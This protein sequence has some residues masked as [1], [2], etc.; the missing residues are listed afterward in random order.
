M[1]EALKSRVIQVKNVVRYRSR[2]W[3]F[4]WVVRLVDRFASIHEIDGHRVYWRGIPTNPVVVDLGGNIGRF[5]N[6]ISKQLTCRVIYVEADPELCRRV[7]FAETAKVEIRNL[8]IGDK[9]EL[10]RLFRSRNSEAT[11]AN[12]VIADKGG[13]VDAFDVQGSTFNFFLERENVSYVDILKIDIEGS[14]IALL[15]S[16]SSETIKRIGQISVEFH[17]FVD[18]SYRPA[19]AR[20]LALLRRNGF[21]DIVYSL[22][23]YSKVLLLNKFRLKLSVSDRV[24]IWLIRNVLARICEFRTTRRFSKRL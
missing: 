21:V 9:N 14:E 11:S 8:A 19:I 15:E 3:E 2:G 12:R 18:P 13:I 6:A 10:M 4:G 16:T 1:Q 20:A 22:P 17:D 24:T 7:V 5:S 23:N